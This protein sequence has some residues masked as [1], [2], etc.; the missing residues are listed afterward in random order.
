[1]LCRD[2]IRLRRYHPPRRQAGAEATRE[3]EEAIEA[4]EAETN[5]AVPKEEA[6]SNEEEE[7]LPAPATTPDTWDEAGDRA[8]GRQQRK[9]RRCGCTLCSF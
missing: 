2:A 6:P 8:A 7:V 4:A 9:I 3:E 1:M 5:V